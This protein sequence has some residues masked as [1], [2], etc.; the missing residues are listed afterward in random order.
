[1]HG[2]RS[3]E[4]QLR[5]ECPIGTG[6]AG[7][8]AGRAQ[9]QRSRVA[10]LAL[11]ARR[12]ALVPMS[13]LLIAGVSWWLKVTGASLFTV[14]NPKFKNVNQHRQMPDESCGGAK[15]AP[16]EKVGRRI[17]KVQQC[18]HER[19]NLFLVVPVT[20]GRIREGQERNRQTERR[21]EHRTVDEQHDALCTRPEKVLAVPDVGQLVSVVLAAISKNSDLQAFSS[22]P[23]S[24][25]AARLASSSKG[26]GPSARLN[27]TRC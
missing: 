8:V 27:T 6:A 26:A 10:K 24:L 25:V 5:P 1:L 7:A 18:R 2:P 23:L 21:A 12:Q 14:G 17:H 22:T 20:L 15:P 4:S 19:H 16:S 13:E 9:G 3:V 11:H